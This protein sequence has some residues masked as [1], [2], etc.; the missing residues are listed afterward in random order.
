M[1]DKKSSAS[2]EMVD[3]DDNLSLSKIHTIRE[4]AEPAIMTE[5]IAHCRI[6]NSSMAGSFVSLLY[7][8]SVVLRDS[9]AVMVSSSV[10]HFN[11]I[12]K[13]GL[14][15]L[16]ATKIMPSAKSRRSGLYQHQYFLLGGPR[17]SQ[18]PTSD[19]LRFCCPKSA[20]KG[21]ILLPRSIIARFTHGCG[22]KRHNSQSNSSGE[23]FSR[24]TTSHR[25]P[26]NQ[27][28]RKRR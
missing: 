17:R 12:L 24:R 25:G 22:G 9:A 19:A 4:T 23:E 7:C 6:G 8:R 16:S 1:I 26:T 27:P 3:C 21:M 18:K 15:L 13:A 14:R 10:E 28:R 20:P 2:F 5:I 11:G